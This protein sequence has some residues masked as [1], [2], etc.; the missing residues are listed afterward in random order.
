VPADHYLFPCRGSGIDAP[1]AT[2]DFLDTRPPRADWVLV[3]CARSRQI[4]E[5]FY[6]DVPPFVE[7]CPRERVGTVDGPT[8]TK[9]C[10][11]EDRIERSG[12]LVV[13]PWGAS[14]EEVRQGLGIVVGAAESAWAP[15]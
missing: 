15:A 11:L 7:M 14:L 12:L 8:L 9:C 6:G 3:G 10:M 1:G 13:V 4:H 2:V 5:S